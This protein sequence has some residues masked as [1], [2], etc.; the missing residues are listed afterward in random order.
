[1][2]VPADLVVFICKQRMFGPLLSR[3]VNG[4]L[5]KWGLC[6]LAGLSGGLCRI[7]TPEPSI[8]GGSAPILV[9]LF[10]LTARGFRDGSLTAGLFG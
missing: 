10:G 5:G 2:F 8:S 4:L 7:W 9:F 6:F 3:F 1:M